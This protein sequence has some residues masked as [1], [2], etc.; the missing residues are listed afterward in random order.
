MNKKQ[1]ERFNIFSGMVITTNEY[2][3]VKLFMEIEE[4]IKET[5]KAFNSLENIIGDY[6]SKETEA[7]TETKFLMLMNKWESP[8]I[9][10]NELVKRINT[11]EIFLKNM[12]KVN[13]TTLK[14]IGYSLLSKKANELLQSKQVMTNG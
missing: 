8:F 2:E 10:C 11:N 13:G 3:G 5:Q 14:E 9:A 12:C 6:H 4:L 7:K 1:Y